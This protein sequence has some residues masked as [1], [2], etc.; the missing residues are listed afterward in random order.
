MSVEVAEEVVGSIVILEEFYQ[1][2]SITYLQKTIERL[3]QLKDL[4]NS[5]K[6]RIKV[7]HEAYGG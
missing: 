1:G 2:S 6:L 3:K 5:G 7:I 4:I